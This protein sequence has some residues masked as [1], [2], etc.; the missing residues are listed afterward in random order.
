MPN[1]F[2]RFKEF[3]VF[4]DL[5]AMKVG[6]DGVLLGAW[7]KCQN[8]ENIL[9]I[10][11]GSGLIALMLA[12]RSSAEIEAIDIDEG[13]YKQARLNFLNSKFK[14]QL[15]A[16]HQSLQTYNPDKKYDLIVSNPPYFTNSLKSPIKERTKARHTDFLSLE[17]LFE[18]SAY[19][20]SEKGIIS[21]IIPFVDF[22]RVN[23][24]A[25]KQ[26]L[27]LSRKTIVYPT[28]QS[29]PN[30]VLLE[31]SFR[32]KQ[33]EETQLIVE[34]SRHQYSDEFR[35]LTADYYLNL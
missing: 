11:T 6:T 5:C 4:H 12:Q 21:I 7:A 2:F 30:R 33:I 20:L 3:T 1:P 29:N 28:P 35:N 31:Y 10:G 22:D 24:I 26:L 8:A 15:K 27:F 16:I 17:E 34:I 23:Q 9:D 14:N 19:L 18:K 32:K 13:A 25:D